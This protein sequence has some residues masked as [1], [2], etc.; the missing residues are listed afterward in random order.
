MSDLGFPDKIVIIELEGPE[1]S[2]DSGQ[3]LCFTDMAQCTPWLCPAREAVCFSPSW[4]CSCSHEA[5]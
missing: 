5:I 4:M 3:H 2:V 1:I